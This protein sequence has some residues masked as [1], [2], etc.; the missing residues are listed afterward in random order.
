MRTDSIYATLARS[1]RKIGTSYVNDL[2]IFLAETAG[3]RFGKARKLVADDWGFRTSKTALCDG[4]NSF[5]PFWR[6]ERA[7]EAAR[8][9]EKRSTFEPEAA[10]VLAQ[11]TFETLAS[12]ELDP[13]ILLGFARLEV[14][15]KRAENDSRR[16]AVLEKRMTDASSKLQELRDPANADKPE[17]RERLMAEVDEL[18]GIGKKEPKA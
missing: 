1:D 8:S 6:L 3:D 17:V 18:M 2:M 10:R 5:L 11:R 7:A 16:V 12:Q 4:Y 13:K 14:M 9:T 15:R